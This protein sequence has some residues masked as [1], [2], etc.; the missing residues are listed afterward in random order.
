MIHEE[1]H[2]LLTR[3]L[4]SPVVD[5]GTGESVAYKAIR[6]PD[7]WLSIFK[8]KAIRT[9]CAN[10]L[11]NP[12]A[13]SRVMD[14][15]ADGGC[16]IL[17]ELSK[18]ARKE[19]AKRYQIQVWQDGP[20]TIV[21]R[22]SG[23]SGEISRSELTPSDGRKRVCIVRYG[24][25]GDHLMVSPLLQH[26]RDEGWHITYNCSE[27]GEDIYGK[28]PRIDNLWVQEHGIVPPD[29]RIFKYWERMKEGFD[30]F[31]NLSEVIEGDLLR[32]EGKDNYHDPWEKRQA[33]CS[34]NYFDAHFRRAGLEISGRLP[35]IHLTSKETD[36]AKE[37]VH[38]VRR[39]A[40]R[41]MVVLWNPVGSSFHKVYPWVFDV[42]NLIRE[43]RDD[44]GIIVISDA[45]GQ[46]LVGNE[47]KDL[48][49]NG[50]G[51]YKIRQSIA[52][53]SAVDAVV[54]VETWSMIASFAFEAPLVGLLSHSGRENYPRRD[55]DFLLSPSAHDCPCW[56][57]HQL[58][59]SRN[60]CP[61]GIY[62]KDT[63][64]CMDSIPPVD[65]YNAL[66]KIYERKRD[67]ND[68]LIAS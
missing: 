4:R 51:K 48:V 43:N 5:V 68:S 41:S 3:Y 20:F 27:R 24:A 13:V 45:L 19:L 17:S 18:E 28:D 33:E 62:C 34:G 56:P 57:C 58:H 1:S 14:P 15:L 30:H 38:R 65:V 29:E 26:Y 36:W 66:M 63:T 53:H 46:F 47:F 8:P 12:D 67:G 16:L 9:V 55:R 44:I 6:V 60:S 64:L 10:S 7:D 22:L 42:W 21:K 31:V 54:T 50:G 59:Y 40:G 49:H 39:K 23:K 37:E 61:R 35:K 25:I 32:I 2:Y 11:E 52:L